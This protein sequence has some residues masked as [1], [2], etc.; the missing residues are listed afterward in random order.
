[1]VNGGRWII[2]TNNEKN[3]IVLRTV[4]PVAVHA[5]APPIGYGGPPPPPPPRD[6]YMDLR[7]GL[8]H[9]PDVVGFTESE[10]TI[11]VWVATCFKHEVHFD[12]PKLILRLVRKYLAHADLETGDVANMLRP[13]PIA[14]LF[15]FNPFQ[16]KAVKNIGYHI[17]A[18]GC[19]G[20][21]VR[22]LLAAYVDCQHKR[23]PSAAT[24]SDEETATDSDS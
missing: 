15:K 17:K 1:M 18:I 23:D 6:L 13:R 2:E 20:K 10:T 3:G 12:I 16:S 7:K 21:G 19:K 24:S 22:Y 9:V 5:P 11:E 4:G 14:I 8:E